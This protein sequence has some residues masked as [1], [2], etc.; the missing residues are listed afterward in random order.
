[1]AE[2]TKFT[3]EEL[4]KVKEIQESYFDIQNQFG[5]LSL[6]KLRTEQQLEVFSTNENNLRKQF[7]KIQDD[8]KTF[9]DGIT[10]KYGEGSLDPDTGV[11]T[12]STE[13]PKNN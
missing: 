13:F 1:M 7:S 9:L 5:Q 10:E 4:K 6:A 3:E 11:F 12:A 2:E 8:E